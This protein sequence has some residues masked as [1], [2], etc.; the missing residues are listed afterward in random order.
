MFIYRLNNHFLSP[1]IINAL[2]SIYDITTQSLLGNDCLMYPPFTVRH[3][4]FVFPQWHGKSYILRKS[5]LHSFP[6]DQLSVSVSWLTVGHRTVPESLSTKK[7]TRAQQSAELTRIPS[8]P[9]PPWYKS[10]EGQRRNNGKETICKKILAN[11]FL[12]VM[13]YTNVKIQ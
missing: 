7:G 6:S 11:H 10:P 13:K 8:S 2:L 3:G 12:D 1:L 9:L 5:F 4:L